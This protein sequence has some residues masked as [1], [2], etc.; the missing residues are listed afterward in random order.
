M[1][2]DANYERNISVKLEHVLFKHIYNNS[3]KSRIQERNTAC[4]IYPTTSENKLI[5]VSLPS[6]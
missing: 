1:V 5:S 6:F 2:V 3:S 4:H